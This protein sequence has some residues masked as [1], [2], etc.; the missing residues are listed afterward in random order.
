MSRRLFDVVE[1][2]RGEVLDGLM[3]ALGRHAASA[4]MVLRDDF[5]LEESA[6]ALLARLEPHLVEQK[7]S[8]SWPGTTLL[9][10]E[11]TVLRFRLNETVVEELIAAADGLFEWTQPRL[12]EDLALVRNDGTAV[13]GSVCHEGDAFLEVTEE[14]YRSLIEAVP[15]IAMIIRLHVE[16]E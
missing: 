6:R 8:A 9:D 5:D 10:E 11:A 12:P 2:P 4:T 13:L 16:L 3:R 14:E 1:E 15:G 7:R